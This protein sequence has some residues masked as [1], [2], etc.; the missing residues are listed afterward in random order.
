MSSFGDVGYAGKFRDTMERIATGM[1]NRL[2][3]EPFLAKVYDANVSTQKARVMIPGS[4]LDNL[5]TVRFGMDKI[6]RNVMADFP[7]LGVDAPGDIVRVFG[8]SGSY[9]IMDFFSGSPWRLEDNEGIAL[10]TDPSFEITPWI[11]GYPSGWTNFWDTDDTPTYYQE[12]SDVLHGKYALK[13]LRPNG[14][15]IRVH[16]RTSFPVVAGEAITVSIWL[17]CAPTGGQVEFGFMTGTTDAAT[18]FFGGGSNQTAS[19]T[20]NTTW[21]RHEMTFT[22]PA[23]HAFARVTFRLSTPLSTDMTFWIDDTFSKR[24]DI[25]GF[26]SIDGSDYSGQPNLFTNSWSNFGGVNQPAQYRKI[27]DMVD[28]R[29]LIHSGTMGAPAFTLPVGFRPSW[30]LLVPQIAS[31]STTLSLGNLS[32]ETDGRVMPNDPAGGNAYFAVNSSFSTL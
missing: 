5:M 27:Q 1:I 15:T 25:P 21:T 18:E 17:K 6:P 12:V 20:M 28:M 9:F 3:P 31:T 8:V 23:T 24:A 10:H 19:Q 13:I 32:I 2:R 11:N 16:N 29:G 30:R 4:T 26:I 14:A 22:V 7:E